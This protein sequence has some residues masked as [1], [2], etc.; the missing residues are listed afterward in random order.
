M[1]PLQQ[2]QSTKTVFQS[3]LISVF[4]STSVSA[5]FVNNVSLD[6][7]N[8]RCNVYDEGGF[9]YQ[10]AT[11]MAAYEVPKGSGLSTIFSGSYWVGA[12][13]PNGVPHVTGK[14]YNTGGS[15]SGFHSGPI[16]NPSYYGSSAYNTA[17]QNALWK[18]SQAEI[19]EHIQLAQT[20]GYVV[21]TSI[22]N[23]PGNG[24]VSMGVAA[25]LAPY[26]DLNHNGV[27]EPLQGEYPDIRGDEAVYIIMNDE[28][29]LPDGN[30]L[31]IELHAMFY[32]YSAGNYINN[33]TFLNLQVFNRSTT[34]YV[35]YHQTLFLDFDI[36]S[37]SDD[38]AGCSPEKHLLFAYNGD[39]ID[40]S[41]AGQLGYGV[42]PPCQGV[43]CLSHPLKNARPF[44]SV[45]LTNTDQSLWSFMNGQT[46]SGAPWVNPQ[47]NQV[48]NFIYPDNP[49]DPNG[50]SEEAL[51][52]SPSDRRGMMTIYE[53]NFQPGHKICSDYAFIY[54]R[55]GTRL[56]NVQNVQNIAG[57]LLALY[58]ST[59]QFPCQSSSTNQVQELLFNPN[60]LKVYPNPSHGNLTVTWG[61]D[62]LTTLTL[63]NSL[64]QIIL[65]QELSDSKSTSITLDNIP[66]GVY[67]LKGYSKNQVYTKE[68]VVE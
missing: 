17:Y 33:T 65:E 22:L 48:T 16:A 55:S 13:D 5:Q 24:N 10:N 23:W 47:T 21:P 41:D 1:Q 68:V 49:N 19:D 40:G 2:L 14:K 54:D 29:Y 20:A 46:E 27:Y 3:I 42:N 35:Q 32:Q 25:Q 30:Q 62:P 52:H 9:F 18:V 36:G 60:E 6:R 64:G 44:D 50:W 66:S 67:F 7:N 4:I 37:Y 12:L 63:F 51:Q 43:M 53:A 38:F 26:I 28:S 8:V 56:Q 11:G 39:D 59:E 61:E 57:S 58:A 45:D 15:D 34:P 31:G